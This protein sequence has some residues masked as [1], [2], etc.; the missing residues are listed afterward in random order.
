MKDENGGVKKK[1]N[2]NN[3]EV[4]NIYGK[5]SYLNMRKNEQIIKRW[6]DYGQELFSM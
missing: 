1:V 6:E 3:K 4:T 2:N 5:I